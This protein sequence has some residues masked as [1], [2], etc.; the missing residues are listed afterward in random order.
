MFYDAEN[1]S[2]E[3]NIHICKHESNLLSCSSGVNFGEVCLQFTVCRIKE[4]STGV[5]YQIPSGGGCNAVGLPRAESSKL[6]RPYF[7]RIEFTT[8][9]Q[10]I[11]NLFQAN[12][13]TISSL[14]SNVDPSRLHTIYSDRLFRATRS[15]SQG[16]SPFAPQPGLSASD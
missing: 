2:S 3:G 9:L 10:R 13:D 7:A 8:N 1:I 16:Y 15:T 12:L 5:F 6:H 4:I 14:R 11:S